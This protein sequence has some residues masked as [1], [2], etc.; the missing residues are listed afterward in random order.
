VPGAGANIAVALLDVSEMGIRLLI[1]EN[2]EP[3]QLVEVRLRGPGHH[4]PAKLAAE[5]IW[6]VPTADRA[7]CV[8]ACFREKLALNDLQRL[9]T[10]SHETYPGF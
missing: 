6:S 2:V 10:L 5:I 9:A 3:G 1:S 4:R 8:G 7:Y